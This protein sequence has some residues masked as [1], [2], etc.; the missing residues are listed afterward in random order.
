MGTLQPLPHCHILPFC[1]VVMKKP[2]HSLIERESKIS[3][4]CCLFYSC[5]Q[6]GLR[7]TLLLT[8]VCFHVEQYRDLHCF[9]AIMLGMQWHYL[10]VPNLFQVFME[11]I[12][13]NILGTTMWARLRHSAKEV[14]FWSAMVWHPFNV[15]QPFKAVLID[16]NCS[17]F[18]ITPSFSYLA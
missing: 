9:L 15:I 8:I 18:L 6:I 1:F 17:C 4:V 2:C 7:A 12:S 11:N 10:L 16:F 3:L 5:G 13:T 14:Y